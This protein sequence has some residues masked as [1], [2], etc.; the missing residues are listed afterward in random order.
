MYFLAAHYIFKLPTP[1]KRLLFFLHSNMCSFDLLF[2]ALNPPSIYILNAILHVYFSNK[3]APFGNKHLNC[4][5]WYLMLLGV[6]KLNIIRKSSYFLQWFF[7]APQCI[8]WRH[9]GETTDQSPLW[10]PWNWLEI[11]TWLVPDNISY[12]LC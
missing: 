10:D 4:H 6:T 1:L 3:F 12:G 7:F 2:T 8:A 9:V 5:P 11:N